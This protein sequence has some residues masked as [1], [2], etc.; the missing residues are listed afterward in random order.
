MKKT[1]AA[2]LVL[3][4]S[5]VTAYSVSLL[6][7]YGGGIALAAV[8]LCAGA[9]LISCR[10]AA[11]GSGK[12][13]NP[14]GEKSSAGC[15]KEIPLAELSAIW[16]PPEKDPPAPHAGPAAGPGENEGIIFRNPA[17]RRFFTEN[18]RDDRSFSREPSLKA[19]ALDIL[20]VLDRHGDCP[21]VV[22]CD[23]RFISGKRDPDAAR[24]R[25][26]AGC[27]RT[28]FDIL[29]GVCLRD[30][31]L[32]VAKTAARE[33]GIGSGAP[34][35]IIAALGH[36]L[37]KIPAF[38]DRP[39][40]HSLDH[41]R[42]SALILKGMPSFALLSAAASREIEAAVIDHHQDRPRSPLADALRIADEKCR[43]KEI[44]AA[45]KNEPPS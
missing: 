28:A 16:R 22:D 36:D 26:V 39:S 11:A 19:L 41:P 5:A 25:T 12:P 9:A 35:L 17:V 8:V 33:C 44:D 29:S 18:I 24:K 34:L 45:E 20:A 1:S 21:S 30:H 27:G 32:A 13:D 23:T 2:I 3:T 31:A 4:S 14:G 42:V 7:G 38:R 10:R 15:R 6:C 43:Q 40:F 37:G